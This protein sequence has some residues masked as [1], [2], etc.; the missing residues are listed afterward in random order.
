MRGRHGTVVAYLALFVALGG[1]GYAATQIGSKQI[2][3]N[4]IKSVDVKNRSL[5]AK[6][7]KPGQL[8][9]GNQGPQGAPGERGL[10]GER[11]LPGTNGTNGTNGAPGT[12]KGYAF[13]PA[14]GIVAAGRS[15]GVISVTKA[16]AGIYCFDLDF[17]PSVVVASAFTNNNATSTT[18]TD[19]DNATV[20][21]TCGTAPHDAIVVTRGS[22]DASSTPVDVS[23]SV[24]FE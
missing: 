16:A 13:V 5:L 6:D 21:A 4:S 9:A 7:F 3:N 23:F 14:N 22:N 8:P 19:A 1:T 17:T 20:E 10:Q 2:A 18:T 11:G 15:K 12:A 24:I